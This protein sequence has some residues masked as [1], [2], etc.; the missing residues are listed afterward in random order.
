M[1]PGD[2]TQ[3]GAD[4]GPIL[5]GDR[6]RMTMLAETVDAVIGI[7][8]H[9]DSHEAVIADP[10]GRPIATM[11]IGNDSAGYARVLAAIAKTVPG[12]RVAVCVEGTR[13]YGIGLARALAAAG[14]RVIEC[15]RRS[16][17]RRRGNGK[18]DPIDAHLAV[19]AALRLDAGKLPVPRADGDREALRILLVA[20]QEIR[21]ARTAQA[22]R[23]RALLLAGDDTDRR[24]A[25]N[26]LTHRA[27]ATLAGRELPAGAG[28][29][30]A[31]RQA[32]I[33]RLAAA[34]D[35]AR[36]QLTGNHA[37][38]LAIVD[39][40]APGLTSRFGV[41][42]VSAAQAIVSF[43]HPGRCRSEAAFAA[44]G[45]TS[46]IPASSGQTIRHRLN[47]GG[48]RALN[49]AIHAIAVTRMRSC[50]RTRAY[51]ARRTAEGKTNREI[52]RC[53]KR[54][55]ARELYRQLTRSMKPLT[56]P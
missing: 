14:L 6:G 13:S 20:R 1:P 31:V 45:G 46:A 19:L 9:R 54:Y 49:R 26:A 36:H 56:S 17:K 2:S 53:L 55:I 27:L 15:E 33:R 42:P 43:S 8:T 32:E 4:A 3:A 52:R 18:S 22:A 38:L 16:R 10:A 37:Q 39:D 25:R 50:P 34:L 41:G 51:V 5:E 28:R 11:R 44:L 35:Q 48:D 12:P 21:A 23:L 7:D 40:I 24:A 30:Q 47:R 29:E